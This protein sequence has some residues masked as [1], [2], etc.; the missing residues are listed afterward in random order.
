MIGLLI[1]LGV[2]L[3]TTEMG[4]TGG[5]TIREKLR[6]VWTRRL[7]KDQSIRNH[8]RRIIRRWKRR[9]KRWRKATVGGREKQRRESGLQVG[10]GIRATAEN[11]GL[12][13]GRKV[14]AEGIQRRGQRGF[15]K[16]IQ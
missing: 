14:N 13:C 2:G 12:H 3:A 7:V 16:G 9:A 11:T 10:T 4:R 6:E 8:A 1:Y 15:R 5:S